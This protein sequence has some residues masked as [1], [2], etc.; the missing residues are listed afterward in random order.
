MATALK[1]FCIVE[2]LDQG[3][4]LAGWINLNGLT[5]LSGERGRGKEGRGRGA[6]VLTF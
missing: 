1:V 4:K 5:S 3:E 6:M 2:I